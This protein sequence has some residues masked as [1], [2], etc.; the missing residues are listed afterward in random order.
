MIPVVTYLMN[1]NIF[2]SIISFD[3]PKSFGNIKP[4]HMSCK[5]LWQS[6]GI[7]TCKNKLYFL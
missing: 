1:K 7:I 4:F 5:F 3:K 6:D 2:T